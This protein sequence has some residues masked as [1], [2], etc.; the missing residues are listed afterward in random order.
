MCSREQARARIIT[1]AKK[2]PDHIA[3]IGVLV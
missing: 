3:V 1:R 2:N